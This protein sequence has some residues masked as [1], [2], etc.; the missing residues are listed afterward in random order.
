MKV[1]IKEDCFKGENLSVY[2]GAVVILENDNK[3]KQPIKG[4]S[5]N[6]LAFKTTSGGR[7]Y[8]SPDQYDEVA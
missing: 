8:L 5:G 3:T 1:R 2:N 4:N 6:T 7:L